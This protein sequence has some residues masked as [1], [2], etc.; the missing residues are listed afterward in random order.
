MDRAGLEEQ[1]RALDEGRAFVRHPRMRLNWVGGSEARGWLQDL[2]T[3]D[4]AELRPFRTRRS[5]LLAP[6]GRIRADF[7]VLGFGD[8]RQSFILAQPED[9][10]EDLAA[11][12]R[13]YV[14]SSDVDLRPAPFEIASVPGAGATLPGSLEAWRPSVLG[15]G[16]DLVA[17]PSAMDRELVPRLEEDGFVEAGRLA[18]EA[19]RIRRGVPRFPI[20][21]DEDSLP[22][23]A[24]LDDEVV[25]DRAKGCYLG[26]ES[27]AKVRNLGHPTRVVLALRS[28]SP[29]EA[30]D[31]VLRRGESG[32]EEAGLVTSA[33]ARAD[34]SAVIARIVWEAR[35]SELRTGSGAP[36]HP[37]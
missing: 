33:D 25:I 7:H 5:L 4:V 18:V 28:P 35:D 17:V 21:L 8:A 32:D 34:G 2:V 6:T 24:G 9:Q 26:Q 30:G 36:L 20:D 29:V 14:L 31:V 11:L 27:V 12:L 37:R 23:E 13:P 1:V 3:A 19:W 10:P 22:A 15:T 16:S